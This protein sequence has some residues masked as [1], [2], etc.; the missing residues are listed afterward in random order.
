[1]S[2]RALGTATPTR[3]RPARRELSPFHRTKLAFLT[4]AW[5][6]PAAVAAELDAARDPLVDSR[7]VVE[8]PENT[9]PH[10]MA[11]PAA[12]PA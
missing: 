9:V 7:A 10:S 4:A 11:A 3:A 1:M 5:F 6:E 12:P 8:A 2:E